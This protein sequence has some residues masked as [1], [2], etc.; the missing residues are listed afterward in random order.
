MCAVGTLLLEAILRQPDRYRVVIVRVQIAITIVI[1][2]IV[3][4]SAD[5]DGLIVLVL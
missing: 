5:R 4:L 1:V 2:L 3:L